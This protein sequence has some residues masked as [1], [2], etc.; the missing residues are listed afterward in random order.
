MN[1]LLQLAMSI[2]LAAC[3]SACVNEST[4]DDADASALPAG[5]QR[6]QACLQYQA[7]LCDYES[8][9]CGNLSR[10]A[11]EDTASSLYCADD[12][13]VRACVDALRMAS[14][15]D[16]LAACASVVDREPAIYICNRLIGKVCTKRAACGLGTRE[17]CELQMNMDT[18]CAQALGI[19]RTVD[20]CML[21]L[22]Q[23]TCGQLETW[24]LPAD[25]TGVVK[26]G[27]L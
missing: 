1:Q 26:F 23:V 19:G 20:G 27:T 3:L 17:S 8:D 15:G 18:P 22:D 21:R 14:C 4:T 10:S 2:P 6:S 13:T 25:C 5:I 9:R 11:C 7:A 24:S 16:E 12:Q